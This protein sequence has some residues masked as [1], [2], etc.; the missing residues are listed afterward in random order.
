MIG[1][2]SKL[3]P[4]EYGALTLAYLGDSVYEVYVRTHLLMKGSLPVNKLHR[5]AKAFVSAAAQSSAVGRIES[6]LSEEE[7]AVYRRGRN[8]KSATVPKNAVLAD[9][10]RATGLEALVGYLY[11]CKRTERLDEIMSKIIDTTPGACGDSEQK[12]EKA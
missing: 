1:D 4:R 7:L 10:R 2:F 11:L 5:A 3:S 8:A 6:M 12:V 9:Y